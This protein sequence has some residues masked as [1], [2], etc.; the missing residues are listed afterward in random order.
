MKDYNSFTDGELIEHASNGDQ[1]AFQY[2][3]K[4]HNGWAYGFVL[5]TVRN[6]E[7]AWDITQEGFVRVFKNLSEFRQE[8]SFST[9][10]HRILYNLCIDHWRRT[11][12]RIEVEYQDVLSSGDT[13]PSGGRGHI[14]K[15]PE[16]AL[17]HTE[18]VHLLEEALGELSFEHRTIVVLR[19]IDGLSYEEI[20]EVTGCPRGTVMSRLH[21]ARKNIVQ[22][23]KRH[24]YVSSEI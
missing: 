2:L 17:R 6:P 7:A 13:G 5:K 21:H 3:V 15:T 4:R 1:L 8:S 19:E 24:G 14:F 10:F 20:A 9:W 22:H 23:L 16:K 11:G 18:I 12:R